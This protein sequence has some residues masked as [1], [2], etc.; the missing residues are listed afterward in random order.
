MRRDTALEL[1]EAEM[2][3]LQEQIELEEEAEDD[4]QRTALA[5]LLVLLLLDSESIEDT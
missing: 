4:Y 1:Y 5:V 3:M 2:N